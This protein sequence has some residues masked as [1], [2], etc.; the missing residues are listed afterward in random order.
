M[1]EKNFLIAHSH[2]LDL[3]TNNFK[4]NLSHA[5]LFNGIKGVGKCTTAIQFINSVQNQRPNHAQ[6]F[7]HINTEDNPAMI[8]DIRDLI[9][10][11]NLT[12]SNRNQKSFVILDNVNQLN[13]NSFNALL[14][15]IEEPPN[16]T[17]LILVSHNLKQIPK[18]II[19]RCLKIDF[20]PLNQEHIIEYCRKKK[21]DFEESDIIKFW[22]IIGG[23]IEK[24]LLLSEQGGLYIKNE[25][26][27]LIQTKSL[28]YDKFE[29][30]Y[31][32]ISN[33]YQKYFKLII[34]S[35]Y[36]EKKKIFIK[37]FD[38]KK[39]SRKILT[40]FKNI[41][42]L[43]AKDLNNDKKKELYFILSEYLEI[44]K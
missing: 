12:N 34:D 37:Y 2:L 8:E 38:D 35:L 42:L 41:K 19:S 10:Q 17:I 32:Y 11:V 23:S 29:K 33:D 25:L 24:F 39:F 7:F 20:K 18:T 27:N 44:K 15:T 30:F 36:I 22:D 5:L 14:K 13:T 26:D 3:L 9:K 6:N 40:F 43:S 16:N 1:C 28:E 31:S 4:K 21:I